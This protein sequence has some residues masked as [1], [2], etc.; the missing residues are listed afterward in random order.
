MCK[1]SDAGKD[2]RQKEKGTTE[3][4]MIGWH[5]W[6]KWQ[7]F[8]PASGDDKRQGSLVCCS[9]WCHRAG[10]DWATK[11]QPMCSKTYLDNPKMTG[12]KDTAKR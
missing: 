6:L 5:H 2:W 4:E 8:E 1:D 3:D 10:H 7:E 12:S 11:Q 9:S